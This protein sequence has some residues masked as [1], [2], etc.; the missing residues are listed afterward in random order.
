MESITVDVIVT[1]FIVV[2]H[3]NMLLLTQTVGITLIEMR[4]FAIEKWNGT[5]NRLIEINE[6]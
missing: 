1:A 6:F 5:E 2:L 3:T 4:E